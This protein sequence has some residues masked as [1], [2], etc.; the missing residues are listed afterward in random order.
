M[1]SAIDRERVIG[2]WPPGSRVSTGCF[3]WRRHCPPPRNGFRTSAHQR[4]LSGPLCCR[5]RAAEPFL[6][7]R[8]AVSPSMTVAATAP[9]RPLIAHSAAL[10]R[11]ASITVSAGRPSASSKRA[12]LTKG[13]TLAHSARSP[14][15][16]IHFRPLAVGLITIRSGA[17]GL[18]GVVELACETILRWFGVVRR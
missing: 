10:G 11:H 7:P 1:L 13:H 9:R 17:A 16:A 14:R 8:E 15:R 3:V 12:D 5:S 6:A 18:T 2:G 4:P